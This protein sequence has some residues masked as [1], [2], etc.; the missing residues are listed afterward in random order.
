MPTVLRE[1][2]FPVRIYSDDHEPMHVH[3]IQSEARIFW[4]VSLEPQMTPLLKWKLLLPAMACTGRSSIR[5]SRYRVW[6]PAFSAARS[7]CRKLRRRW[8]SA[9]VI[10]LRRLKQ[11][12]RASTAGKAD[13]RRQQRRGRQKWR[14]RNENQGQMYNHGTRLRL[15]D[16]VRRAGAFNCGSSKINR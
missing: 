12:P 8:A 14:P 4:K 7:G 5:I 9:I 13:D 16:V 2:G 6:S 10:Q 3:V 11:Q 1:R 15:L